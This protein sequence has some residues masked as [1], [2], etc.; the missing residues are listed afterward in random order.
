MTY[1]LLII[2]VLELLALL[3]AVGSQNDWL[4]RIHGHLKNQAPPRPQTNEEDLQRLWEAR[5]PFDQEPEP[6]VPA[7]TPRAVA[8]GL[9]EPFGDPR[10]APWELGGQRPWERK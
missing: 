6:P 4:A 1:L 2:V 9:L 8:E 7:P 5:E 3:L 10:R